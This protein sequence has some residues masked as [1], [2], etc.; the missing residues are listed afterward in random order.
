MMFT[1]LNGVF[2]GHQSCGGLG[3]QIPIFGVSPTRCALEDAIDGLMAVGAM[4]TIN[5]ADLGVVMKTVDHTVAT[6]G[7]IRVFSPAAGHIADIDILE[8]GLQ[9][10]LTR[11]L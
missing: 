9:T 11:R 3:K 7:T 6:V 1:D 10:H 5:Q 2:S 8:A 4:M